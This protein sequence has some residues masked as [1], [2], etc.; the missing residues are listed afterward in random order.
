MKVLIVTGDK[1]LPQMK[2]GLQ[3]SA[4]QLCRALLSRGHRVAVLAG[5][6][7]SGWLG[8][9]AHAETKVRKFFI[10]VSAAKDYSMGAYPV[11]RANIPWESV[12]G[13]VRSENPDAAIVLS[14][15]SVPMALSIQDANVPFIMN[16]QDVEF[17]AHGGD[18]SKLGSV[19]CVA[20]SA[21]TAF[22]YAA[23]FPV[24]PTVIHPIIDEEKYRVSSRQEKVLFI[25]PTPRK[26]V[27]IALRVATLCPDIPFLFVE[28]G[29]LEK[30]MRD[31]L[32]KKL[33]HLPNVS[34]M[35]AQADMRPV[36]EAAKILI[37]P[38]LWEEA[39]GRVAAEAII[40]GIP[41]IAY[42]RG[43]LP[44]AV[45]KGGI[46]LPADASAEDWARRVRELWNDEDMYKSFSKA[47]F[48]ES[49]QP[50]RSVEHKGRL[51]EQALNRLLNSSNNRL[52]P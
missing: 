50:T 51:W 23:H 5:L 7:S 47:A 21:F 34:F 38:S 15:R 2:G 14:V 43:G 46:L 41:V 8:Y 1:Y 26:G 52:T 29:P 24:S 40:S 20:N 33:D 44:E 22:R 27:D 30:K 12:G 37:V 18:L 16:F 42:R 49:R 36:Y 45:G 31:D 13:V 6:M 17:H 3:S 48:E 28:S 11:W 32:F 19:H 10:G 39:Y 35:K 9:K 25:S 4:D